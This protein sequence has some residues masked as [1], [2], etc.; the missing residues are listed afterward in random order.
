MSYFNFVSLLYILFSWP[1]ILDQNGRALYWLKTLYKDRTV[2]ILQDNDEELL[3]IVKKSIINGDIL[4]LYDEACL[5]DSRL[6][7]LYKR[8]YIKNSTNETTSSINEASEHIAI[9]IDNEVIPYSSQFRLYIISRSASPEHNL[10]TRCC[11]VNYNFTKSSLNEYFLDTIF[12]R[13]K[14]A[15]RQGVLT[16]FFPF[17]IFFRLF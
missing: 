15:K 8:R 4:I 10:Q 5:Y 1:L 14:P 3:Q 7:S 11:L 16:I 13:E 2:K 12:E 6:E 9:E 17:L